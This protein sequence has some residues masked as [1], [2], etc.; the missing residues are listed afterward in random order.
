[1]LTIVVAADRAPLFDYRDSGPRREFMNRR[2]KIEMLVIHHET[3]DA[4]ADAAAE[5][6]KRLSLR[7]H[8]ERRGLLLMKRT[9]RLE[10]GAGA[11]E[12]KIRSDH[13][14]DVIRRR[15]LFDIL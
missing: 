6:V 1:V 3:E 10:S 15:D 5:A 13:F 11:P 12:W 7:T 9:K 4:P 8:R 2:R 14:D